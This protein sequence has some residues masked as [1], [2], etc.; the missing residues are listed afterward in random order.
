MKTHGLQSLAPFPKQL[1]AI[2][3]PG[4]AVLFLLN[5]PR[6]LPFVPSF[7]DLLSLSSHPAVETAQSCKKSQSPS[8]VLY[9]L[10]ETCVFTEEAEDGGC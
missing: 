3:S 2:V 1:V 8:L 6:I 9:T 7:P 5:Q 10:L 4:G